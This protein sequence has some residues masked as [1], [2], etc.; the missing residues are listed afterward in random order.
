MF[1]HTTADIPAAEVSSAFVSEIVRMKYILYLSLITD[2]NTRSAW[3]KCLDGHT[4]S[5]DA[6]CVT[7]EHKIQ[8][9]ILSTFSVLK[10][11]TAYYHSQII[12][13][14]TQLVIKFKDIRIRVKSKKCITYISVMWFKEM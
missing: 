4:G 12:F 13:K 5:C 8:L 11:I 7:E 3:V 2:D 1:S 14:N 10:A 6:K 9:I